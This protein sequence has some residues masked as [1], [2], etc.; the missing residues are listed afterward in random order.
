M[1]PEFEELGFNREL[2]SRDREVCLNLAHCYE[3]FDN[4]NK[5]ESASRDHIIIAATYLRRAAA[6][7]LILDE[8][9]NAFSYFERAA[10]LY[11]DANMAYGL[12]LASFSPQVFSK[13]IHVFN[14]NENHSDH[15]NTMY[16]ALARSFNRD[17][18]VD[19]VNRDFPIYSESHIL[20]SLQPYRSFPMGILG[21]PLGAHLDLAAA[22]QGDYSTMVE[23]LAPIFNAYNIA[24]QT[25][26]RDIFHWQ[27]MA[28]P[29]HPAEP[30]I[31][32]LVQ[33]AT[34][35][36]SKRRSYMREITDSFHI[37]DDTRTLLSGII[38]SMYG[39]NHEI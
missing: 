14:N 39:S 11:V 30:D 10:N 17:F 21:I 24:V 2:I 27:R 13:L 6:H 33:L 5:I 26:K 3:S 37:A 36:D 7:S 23:V 19:S 15:K 22:S 28:F 31:F 9:P 8:A 1:R 16:V 32:S 29:F 25:A 4:S 20:E 35:R 12:L 38:D 18:P 34:A